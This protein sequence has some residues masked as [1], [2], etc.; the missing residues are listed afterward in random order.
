MRWTLGGGRGEGG[1][2]GPHPN[3]ALDNTPSLDR[4]SDIHKLRVPRLT[5]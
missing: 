2:G 5:G 4:T 3:N 1:G